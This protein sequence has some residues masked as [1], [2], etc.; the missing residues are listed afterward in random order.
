MDVL[1]DM[2]TATKKLITDTEKNDNVEDSEN[3]LF[4]KSLEP[5]LDLAKG[6]AAYAR[7]QI[8][9]VLFEIEFRE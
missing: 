7:M 6:D 3:M 8:Q 9:K 2:N 1:K 4:C 5:T